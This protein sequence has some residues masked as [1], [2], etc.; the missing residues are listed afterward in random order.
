MTASFT[1]L[2]KGK[3]FCQREP[4]GDAGL[5]GYNRSDIYI[6]ELCAFE[7]GEEYV[8]LYPNNGEWGSHYYETCGTGVF[9]KYFKETV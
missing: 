5:E 7:D 3:A 1:V 4:R 6:F 2:K 8:R 9:K